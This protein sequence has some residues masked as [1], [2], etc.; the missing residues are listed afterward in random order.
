MK[1]MYELIKMSGEL[2]VDGDAVMAAH[3]LDKILAYEGA[4]IDL[5]FRHLIER[6]RQDIEEGNVVDALTHS[7]LAKMDLVEKGDINARVSFAF[8]GFHD[9]ELVA[10]LY[11]HDEQF[12]Q[13]FS[14]LVPDFEYPDISGYSIKELRG[15]TERAMSRDAS[16][17]STAVIPTLV[18]VLDSPTPSM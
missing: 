18:G 17:I 14:K 4:P 11:D 15:Y 5:A 12:A 1:N 7:H 13:W 10:E 9:D 8:E 6:A 3:G 2:L 16:K